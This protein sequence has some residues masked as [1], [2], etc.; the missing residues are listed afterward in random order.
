MT[1]LQ[2]VKDK[3]GPVNPCIKYC[4]NEYCGVVTQGKKQK[5]SKNVTLY[6]RRILR[7]F[8]TVVQVGALCFVVTGKFYK[9]F[10]DYGPKFF[11]SLSVFVSIC[12][13]HRNQI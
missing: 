12:F 11:L 7:S 4:W 10:L 2:K 3:D 5:S 8:E 9:P 13:L 6:I 1:P